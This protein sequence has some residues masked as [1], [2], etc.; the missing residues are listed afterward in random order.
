MRMLNLLYFIFLSCYRFYALFLLSM[1]ILFIVYSDFKQAFMYEKSTLQ[2]R[3][4][5]NN[6]EVQA[7]FQNVRKQL[8]DNLLNNLRQQFP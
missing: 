1:F 7:S 4:N 5:N 3:Y 8:T 6:D 2:A